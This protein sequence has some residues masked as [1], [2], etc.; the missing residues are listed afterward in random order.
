VYLQYERATVQNP[1]NV[2]LTPLD[3]GAARRSASTTSGPAATSTTSSCPTSGYGIGFEFGGG[4]TLAGNHQPFQR[5]LVRWI[6]CRRSSRAPAVARGSRRGASPATAPPVPATQLFRTGGDTSVRGYK[7]LDIGVPLPDGLVGPGHYMARGQRG[8]AAAH[9]AAAASRRPSSTLC[10]STPAPSP[11]GRP[12]CA[13]R[14]AWA[15]R[16]LAQPGRA[17]R[18]GIAYGVQPR[19]FRLHITAGSCFE[20]QGAAVTRWTVRVLVGLSCCWCCWRPRPVV[21]VRA[22]EGS[23]ELAAAAG[24]HARRRC[25]ARA[26][27]A[28]SAGLAHPAHRLGARRPAA[29][30]GGHPPA[31][32][33]AALL[34]RTL[35]LQQVHVARCTRDRPARPQ[36]RSRC[37]PPQDLSLPW[38]VQVED[39]RVGELA[40]QGRAQFEAS[41]LAAGSTP[42]TALRHRVA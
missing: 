27:R 36:R 20:G 22:R 10:S 32:A 33:P 28:R 3:T 12:T 29:G 30:S 37:A 24:S 38:R 42:S 7:F 13:S 35:Q 9:P 17:D 11:S 25:A 41:G 4:F 8:M 18:G 1:N 15:R 5:T 31:M 23:L 2:P 34:Q 16:A 40:Y 19:K 39:L 6:G 26:C 21:V 14:W